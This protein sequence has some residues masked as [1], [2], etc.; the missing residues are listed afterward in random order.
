MSG[1]NK[2]LKAII[3]SAVFAIL[4]SCAATQT[5]LEHGKLSTTTKM[6]ETIFLDPVPER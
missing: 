2:K 6:S 1:I 3:L 4:C 5:A